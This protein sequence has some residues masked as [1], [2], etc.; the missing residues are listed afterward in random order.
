MISEKFAERKRRGKDVGNC[1]EH[2][3]GS[4]LHTIH[5]FPTSYWTDSEETRHYTH[6]EMGAKSR[7]GRSKMS[8]S[9]TPALLEFRMFGGQGAS[10]VESPATVIKS[11]QIPLDPLVPIAIHHTPCPTPQQPAFSFHKI[12]LHSHLQPGYKTISVHNISVRN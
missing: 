7:L 11:L 3:C 10:L 4:D 9:T 8:P 12:F 2:Y 5:P 1:W 6:W